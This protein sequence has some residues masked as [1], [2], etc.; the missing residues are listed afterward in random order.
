MSSLSSFSE[1]SSEILL[2]LVFL[3]GF[4][5]LPFVDTFLL[6]RN[7]STSLHISCSEDGNLRHRTNFEMFRRAMLI[8][9]IK[10]LKRETDVNLKTD[11]MLILMLVVLF[12]TVESLNLYL[13]SYDCIM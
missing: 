1:L 12:L 7:V 2:R 8:C 6:C 11:L 4:V 3:C 13:Y 5:D 9:S 10:D